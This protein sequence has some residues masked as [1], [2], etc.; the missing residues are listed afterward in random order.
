[1]AKITFLGT[2]ASIPSLERD[3]TSFVFSHKKH[4]L[5]VD[6]PGSIVQKLMR[7]KI[8]YR[9]VASIIL[10]HEHPDH[11]YGIPHLIHAQYGAQRAITIFS[12]TPTIARIKKLILLFNLKGKKY[13]GIRYIDVFKR[14]FFYDSHSL[15]M[16]ALRNKHSKDS[17]GVEFLFDKK[18]LLYSSDTALSNN[19]ITHAKNATYLIHDCTGSRQLFN[20]QKSLLSMH[21]DSRSLTG[22]LLRSKLRKII[23]VHFL[24]YPRSQEKAILHELRP[25]GKRL[26]M[27]KDFTTLTL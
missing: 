15:S 24:S 18:T 5:L 11:I 20:K 17:F 3:N 23:P 21:T 12:N 19:I 7:V 6:C 2:A 22:A 13:P 25:F 8:D 4:L 16:R 9:R 26:V 14:S 27:V 10:T 1:M